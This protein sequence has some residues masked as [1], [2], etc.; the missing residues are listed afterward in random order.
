[1]SRSQKRLIFWLGLLIGGQE[2]INVC[3]AI[4]A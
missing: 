1:M 3:V 4:Y 2:V